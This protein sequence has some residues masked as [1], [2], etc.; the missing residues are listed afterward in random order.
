MSAKALVEWRKEGPAQARRASS[1]TRHRP[2]LS[3]A[4]AGRTAAAGSA[5]RA[6]GAHPR[7][8]GADP[9]DPTV[10]MPGVGSPPRRRGGLPRPDCGGPD[11]ELTPA[12]A[13]RTSSASPSDGYV[14]A[15]PRAGGADLNA[16]VCS[17]TVSPPRRRGGRRPGGSRC[18]GQ[19]LTPAQAGRTVDEPRCEKRHGAHP[20]AGGADTMPR[21]AGASALGSPPRRRGGPGHGGPR[22]AATGL[23][24]A[25]AGRTGF[26]RPGEGVRRAHPRA[27]GAD[28]ELS[29]HRRDKAGSP[30]RRRG[31]LASGR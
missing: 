16:S 17:S 7:A 13:G 24:P 1:G 14:R 19:G 5:I 9:D 6:A 3:P 31:G 11:V 29:S 12:Q 8:G 25:Q 22:A 23:T 2:R 21:R 10:R 15:H 4:Q 18:G 26:G 30:P 28:A 27:G 20:R